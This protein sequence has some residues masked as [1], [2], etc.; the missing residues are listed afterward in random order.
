M[1]S[2]S[3]PCTPTHSSSIHFN[4]RYH[5]RITA[6]S[7]PPCTPSILDL[8]LL[9]HRRSPFHRPPH[10]SIDYNRHRYH[11]IA[12]P[13]P[14]SCTP[15]P[16]RFI[17]APMPSHPTSISLLQSLISKQRHSGDEA[18]LGGDRDSSDIGRDTA[19]AMAGALQLRD[20]Q[21]EQRV[22]IELCKKC[23]DDLYAD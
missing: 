4:R 8:S 11:L 21:K 5:F 6:Q 12:S 18:G 19:T 20:E 23:T 22:G 10:F 3:P 9:A 14:P 2:S 17:V 1:P 15:T 16:L 7:P 13:S